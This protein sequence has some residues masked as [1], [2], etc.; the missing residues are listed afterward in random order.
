LD[1]PYKTLGVPRDAS[2]DAIRRAYRDLAKQHHP[3]LNPGNAK[4]EERFKAVS[5]AN[6]ILS[7][8]VKRSQFDRG[9]IDAAGQ[10]QARHPS[11]SEYAKGES[12]RAYS[13]SD[14]Q[15]GGWAEDDLNDMFGSIFA[16][17][18]GS[19]R[20][21]PLKGQD[22]RYA[23]TAEFNDAVMGAT[24]RLTLPDG[25]I[26]DVK[27]PVGVTDGQVL[28][29]RGQGAEGWGGGANGDALI[30]ISVAPH[31]YFTRDG[32]DIRL[33]LPV[34]LTEAVL[35]GSV[36]VPTPSGPVRMRVPAGSDSGTEMRLRGKG[37]PK[38]GKL[39]EGNLYAILRVEI[40]KPDAALEDFLKAWKPENPVDPR[41]AMKADR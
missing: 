24:R 7:D 3:D 37:V 1:D 35:G 15:A 12:G 39:S 14:S 23:L 38:H 18:R 10:E 20:S 28:R 31:N 17:N 16:Q 36:E 41:Q 19:G 40:G 9:E 29:L 27:I 25:R 4:A 32:Q 5:S 13:R 21:G 22:E 34:T 2:A 6:D 26:L 33:E 11:Y 30:E 8:P